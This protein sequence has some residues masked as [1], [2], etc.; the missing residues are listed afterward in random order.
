M[1]FENVGKPFIIKPAVGFLSLGVHKVRNKEE[2][3]KVKKDIKAEIFEIS[4]LFPKS[5][6][7]ISKFIL[8][9]I[10]VGEEFALDVYY[11]SNKEPVILNILKHPFLDGDDVSDRAYITSRTVIEE[12]LGCFEKVLAKAGKTFELNFLNIENFPMHIELIKKQDG[13]VIPVEIN[14]MRFAGWCTTDLA[15]FSFGINVYE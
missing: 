3:E 14:P 11:N 2:W 9:E 1:E 8:E 5:V 15:Y 10:I 12:N 13:E 7:N 6:L 4:K